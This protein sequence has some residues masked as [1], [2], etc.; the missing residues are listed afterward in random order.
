MGSAVAGAVTVGAYL[1]G[2]AE[3]TTVIRF[4]TFIAGGQ[5]TLDLL[6]SMGTQEMTEYDLLAASTDSELWNEIRCR[7]YAILGP[8]GI[9]NQAVIED[10]L[11]VIRYGVGEDAPIAP[12]LRS[13][14]AG[15]FALAK[16]PM[17][18]W[19]GAATVGQSD[20]TIYDYAVCVDL[21]R[22]LRRNVPDVGSV[23]QNANASYTL[24]GNLIGDIATYSSEL[25]IV[26]DGTNNNTT[27]ITAGNFQ[28]DYWT[29]CFHLTSLTAIKFTIPQ[30]Q[31]DFIFAK[32]WPAGSKRS[33]QGIPLTLR[34]GNTLKDLVGKPLAAFALYSFYTPQNND[35]PFEVVVSAE[36]CCHDWREAGAQGWQEIGTPTPPSV[37]FDSNGVYGIVASGSKLVGIYAHNP[38]QPPYSIRFEGQNLSP[39]GFNVYESDAIPTF[40]ISSAAVTPDADGYYAITKQ[41]IALTWNVTAPATTSNPGNN[42]MFYAFC[43]KPEP[44]RWSHTFDFT[45]G[46]HGWTAYNGW[47]TLQADGFHGVTITQ[48]GITYVNLYIQLNTD[49]FALDAVYIEYTDT[50][51]RGNTADMFRAWNQP[52]RQG[53]LV[54]NYSDGTGDHANRNHFACGTDGLNATGVQSLLFALA[55]YDGSTVAVHLIRIYGHGQKP[56]FT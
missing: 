43:Y 53:S 33:D 44:T 24:T 6:S 23:A 42:L 38:T 51:V 8:D 32:Y 47:A 37:A 20:P 55:G 50:D 46:A 27:F 30:N 25:G 48:D 56:A 13:L 34:R 22:V 17:V 40:P 3:I 49:A 35:G 52:N 31:Q 54:V 9:V 7:L 45:T 29:T 4:L 28:F 15:Q 1:T 19:T 36:P 5:G 21:P 14:I 12:H 41:Y 18:M 11:H 2:T 26:L 10:W 39:S 16:Y